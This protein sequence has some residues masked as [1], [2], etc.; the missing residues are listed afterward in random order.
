[1]EKENRREKAVAAVAAFYRGFDPEAY[2][3]YNYTPPRADFSRSDSI[4]P[5]K[6]NCLHKAFSEDAIKG[7]ILVDVGSGPTLY[8]VMSGCEHFN[9]VILSDFLEVNRN[10]LNKWLKDGRSNFDWTPYLKHV[11]ELEGRSSSAW[12]EKAERLRSVV[13][14][15]FPVNVHHPFPFP[16]GSLPA[17]GA[18]CLVS[19]FCLESVSPDVSSFTHALRNLSSLLRNGGHL[20]LIGALGESFYMAAPDVRI[21]VVPLDEA[22]VC[23]SLSASGFDLLQLS[24]YRLTP[25][26]LV[27]V[28]DVKG[29]F[30]AKARKP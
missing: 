23:A 27:G 28:D 8:Q 14:D 20:L 10:E 5:W 17:S 11:C 30:F 24:V 29:V 18:D 3:K 19:S 9:R 22:Q 7:D 26:M 21:P 13:T 12:Q 4:V 6:L 16:P 15:I 2:L 1:M 25:D